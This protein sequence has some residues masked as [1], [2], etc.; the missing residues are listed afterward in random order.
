MCI[1]WLSKFLHF[2]EVYLKL[3]C[4]IPSISLEW[5]VDSTKEVE[6]WPNHSLERMEEF[7][8][9]SELERE[10]NKQKSKEEPIVDLSGDASF[11]CNLHTVFEC[12]VVNNVR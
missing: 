4:H 5:T 1:G 12:V 8:K 6:I 2:V 7:T 9:L 10:S 11:D 3:G